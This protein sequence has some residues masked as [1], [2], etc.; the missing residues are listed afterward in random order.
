MKKDG[1]QLESEYAYMNAVNGLNECIAQIDFLKE[2]F[3]GEGVEDLGAVSSGIYYFLDRL[4]K[5]IDQ[6]AKCLHEEIKR[7]GKEKKAA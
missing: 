5:E 6:H 4:G 2:V 1:A 3:S 7:L